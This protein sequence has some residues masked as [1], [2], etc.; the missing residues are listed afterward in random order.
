MLRNKKR[1]DTTRLSFFYFSAS[2]Q[3]YKRNKAL[4]TSRA[5]NRLIPI[6]YLNIRFSHEVLYLTKRRFNSQYVT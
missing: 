3:K 2:Y 6:T 1:K 5:L 4:D